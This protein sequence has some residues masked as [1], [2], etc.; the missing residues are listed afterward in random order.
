MKSKTLSSHTSPRVWPPGEYCI[1]QYGRQCPSG[2]KS[3]YI[4]WLDTK[5]F[6][7]NNKIEGSVPRGNYTQNTTTIFF[8]CRSD[9]SAENY[10][11]LP[12]TS[13]FYLLRYG[14]LCQKVKGMTPS[15]QYFHFNE[16]IDPRYPSTEKSADM[17]DGIS[18]YGSPHPFVDKSKYEKGIMLFYCYYDISDS[19]RGFRVT[20]DETG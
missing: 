5:Q 12:T 11:E 20:V 1:Y 14:K 17:I 13:P 8:C 2:F 18:K 7:S 9:G 19:L 15:S 10:I 16:D 4:T 6:P 3:G